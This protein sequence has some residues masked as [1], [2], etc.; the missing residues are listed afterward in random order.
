VGVDSLPHALEVVG[1]QGGAAVRVAPDRFAVDRRVRRGDPYELDD[2][3]AVRLLVGDLV[4]R[5]GGPAEDADR[6]LYPPALPG[7]PDVDRL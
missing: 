6:A 5:Q 4:A 7:D 3:P 2:P 1:G